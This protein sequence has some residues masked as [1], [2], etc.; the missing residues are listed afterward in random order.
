MTRNSMK[1]YLKGNIYVSGRE[2]LEGRNWNPDV[3]T[4]YFENKKMPKL[5]LAMEFED[6]L[7]EYSKAWYEIQILL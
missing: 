6:N 1:F 5:A 7:V 4:E 2:I 3:L